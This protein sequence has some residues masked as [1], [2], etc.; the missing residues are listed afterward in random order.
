M[1]Q[2]KFFVIVNFFFLLKGGTLL[3]RYVIVNVSDIV[4]F[5]GFSLEVAFSGHWLLGVLGNERSFNGT[6]GLSKVGSD[7][8]HLGVNL[9]W[10]HPLVERPVRATKTL[11]L[12]RYKTIWNAVIFSAFTIF[13]HVQLRLL[14]VLNSG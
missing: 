9:L 12:L 7:W 11:I 2:Q 4:S 10:V 8:L 1:F 5:G 6:T 14:D 3:H 13:L